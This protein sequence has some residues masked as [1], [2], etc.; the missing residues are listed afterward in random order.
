MIKFKLIIV[1]LIALAGACYLYAQKIYTWTDA[2]GVTHISD[3]PPPQDTKVDDVIKYDK[4]PPLEQ[5]EIQQKTDALRKRIER[6]KKIDAAQRAKVTAAEAEKKAQETMATAHEK[7][8][9]NQEYVRELSTR[10]W[11]R[12]K[13]RKRI[14]RI[15][16]ETEAIQSEA[17]I[18]AREAEEA[19]RKARQAAAEAGETP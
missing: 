7:I 11:K 13:F 5:E 6:Q 19:A 1:T 2:N 16:I 12:R 8:Q 18:A 14:D 10:R 17:E 9:E 3:Q 15:K 4:K